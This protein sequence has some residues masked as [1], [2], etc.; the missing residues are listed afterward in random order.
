MYVTSEKGIHFKLNDRHDGKLQDVVFTCDE[1][2][3]DPKTAV[4]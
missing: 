4:T 2:S 1:L 3:V